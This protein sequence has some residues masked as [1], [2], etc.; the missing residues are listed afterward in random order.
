MKIVSQKESLCVRA[1]WQLLNNEK[2]DR[3]APPETS[4]DFVGCQRLLSLI[5]DRRTKLNKIGRISPHW[6]RIIASWED[7]AALSHL[8]DYRTLDRQLAAVADHFAF[9]ANEA[10]RRSD[11]V[12]ALRPMQ[13]F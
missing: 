6:G 13:A 2:T 11:N 10:N 3:S 8:G 4:E 5:V 12:V 1:F 7:F 9:S